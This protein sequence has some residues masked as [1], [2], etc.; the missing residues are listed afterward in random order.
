MNLLV[1]LDPSLS[2]ARVNAIMMNIRYL[3][4]VEVV[5]LLEA[6]SQETLDTILLSPVVVA[7]EPEPVLQ[8]A[9][10]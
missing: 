4:G 9:M 3:P 7:P 6:I 1:R 2:T 8:E 5:C 10:L